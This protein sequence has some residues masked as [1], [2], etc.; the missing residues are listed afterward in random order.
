MN[1]TSSLEKQSLSW[2]N[3]IVPKELQSC[4]KLLQGV[5]DIT[6]YLADNKFTYA[7]AKEFVEWLAAEIESHRQEYGFD[8]YHD[9]VTNTPCCDIDNTVVCPLNK[10]NAVV[11]MA[12]ICDKILK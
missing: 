6:N 9:Y 7:E 11:E 2:D 1:N 12:N 10:I 5:S 3:S 8:T 4:I